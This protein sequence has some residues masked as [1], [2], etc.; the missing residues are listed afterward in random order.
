M[1]V[2]FLVRLF[3]LASKNYLGSEF[4]A[5]LVF[6]FYKLIHLKI[7]KL[8]TYFNLQIYLD[9]KMSLSIQVNL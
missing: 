4:F 8:S 3:N 7:L 1:T 2:T 5:I 9:K 6:W